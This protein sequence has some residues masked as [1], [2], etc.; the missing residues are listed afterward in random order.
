M[1][2]GDNVR[3]SVQVIKELLFRWFGW[4]PQN[5][6]VCDHPLD[7]CYG[8]IWYRAYRPNGHPDFLYMKVC[9]SCL[10]NLEMEGDNFVQAVEDWKQENE[11][12]LLL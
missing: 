5:C 2:G 12:D 6:G 9:S 10:D 1:Y 7:R 11:E 8:K 3:V 4:F